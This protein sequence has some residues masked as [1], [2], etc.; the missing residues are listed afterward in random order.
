MPNDSSTGGPLD[1]AASPPYGVALTTIIQNWMVPLVGLPGDKVVVYDQPVPP[2][3]PEAGDA[4]A[5]VRVTIGAADT[6]PFVGHDPL[7]AAGLGAD[8]LQRQET[9]DCLASFYDLGSG[10][11]SQFYMSRF[12]DGTAIGQNREP[13]RLS[14]ISFTGAGEPTGLPVL[15]KQRWQYRVDLPFTLRRQVDRSY[16]VRNLVTS[17]IDLRANT[18]VPPGELDRVIPV[19]PPHP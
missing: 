18:E 15:L 6:F 2:M 13:L 14:A 3:I 19:P 11:L 4:W 5:A 8:V 1:P 7:A 9:I 12:R 17:S 16:P 10:G